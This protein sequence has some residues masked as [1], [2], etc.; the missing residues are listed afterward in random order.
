MPELLNK[1]NVMPKTAKNILKFLLILVGLLILMYGMIYFFTPKSQMPAEYKLE[2]EILNK[3]NADLAA[4]Q[5]QIDSII[6]IYK[7]QIDSVDS[8]IKNLDVKKTEINNYYQ[9]LSN[10]ANQYTP[11]QLSSFF[12]SRYN[13]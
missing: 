3:A 10:Q 1:N 7:Y 11:A 9:V 4:K 12:K 13:Y 5:R 6:A 2:L 8:T